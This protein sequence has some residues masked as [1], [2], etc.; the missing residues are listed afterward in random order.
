[1]EMKYVNQLWLMLFIW[2]F[3][4]WSILP[5]TAWRYDWR[6]PDSYMHSQGDV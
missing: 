4:V 2:A 1:M 6:N 5:Y 3:G